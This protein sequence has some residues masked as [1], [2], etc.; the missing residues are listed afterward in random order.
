MIGNGSITLP[1]F[2]N[3]GGYQVFGGPIVKRPPS[4]VG[5]NMTLRDYGCRFNVPTEDFKTPPV[6]LT[7]MAL[8]QALR[9]LWGGDP[10]YV[11]C[12]AGWG[13]TGTFMALLVKA[14]GIE[15]PIGWLRENYVEEAVETTDQARYVRDFVIPGR[16]KWLIFKMKVTAFLF[17]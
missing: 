17:P 16:I 6:P 11:G 13:R 3:T 4:M 14:W 5:V 10:V 9:T 2:F 15:N 12:G 7:L 1:G 8:E